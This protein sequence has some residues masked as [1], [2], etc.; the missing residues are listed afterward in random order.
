MLFDE[1]QSQGLSTQFSDNTK[2]AQTQSVM[3][4]KDKSLSPPMCT[5][6]PSQAARNRIQ[7]VYHRIRILGALDV[8]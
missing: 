8:K 7:A 6:D 1:S 3:I 5:N 2:K 4:P